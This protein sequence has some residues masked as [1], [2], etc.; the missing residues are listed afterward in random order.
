MGAVV[1]IGAD[2]D[3]DDV[4]GSQY[5]HRNNAGF[6]GE[7]RFNVLIH[8]LMHFHVYTRPGTGLPKSNIK[9]KKKKKK[10]KKQQRGDQKGKET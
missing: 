5:R 6:S 7:S 3:H 9:K 10:G 8:L 2:L 4:M 1:D